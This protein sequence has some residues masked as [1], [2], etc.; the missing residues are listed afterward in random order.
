MPGKDHFLKRIVRVS[1]EE[2]N[3]KMVSE[4]TIRRSY[5]C[6]PLLGI[7]LCV[8]NANKN[9]QLDKLSQSFSDIF[10]NSFI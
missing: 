4:E 8:K 2:F 10:H 3:L 6:S 7:L 1:G 9:R 5:E